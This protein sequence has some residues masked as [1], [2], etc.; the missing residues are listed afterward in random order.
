LPT[1]VQRRTITG[2]SLEG[3]SLRIISEPV[4][5]VAAPVPS[6]PPAEPE[7]RS[8]DPRE[9]ALGPEPAGPA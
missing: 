4:A 7:P 1:G 3:P 5:A 9:P 8:P 6:D 2:V